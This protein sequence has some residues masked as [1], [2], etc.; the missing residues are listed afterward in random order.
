ME[1][2]QEINQQGHGVASIFPTPSTHSRQSPEYDR[3]MSSQ[4]AAALAVFAVLQII[5]VAKMGGAL[6]MHLGIFLTLGG[7]SIG[8]R[9]LESRWATLPQHI[10]HPALLAAELRADVRDL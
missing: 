7:F 10:A 6:V 2:W 1:L 4:V 8:A 3:K 5:I 9:A